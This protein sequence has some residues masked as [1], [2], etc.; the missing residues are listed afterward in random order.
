MKYLAQIVMIYMHVNIAALGMKCLHYITCM[1]VQINASAA[2]IAK[3]TEQVDENGKAD[4]G[5]KV[6]PLIEVIRV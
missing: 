1:C 3:K 4:S 2:N 6:R 5:A